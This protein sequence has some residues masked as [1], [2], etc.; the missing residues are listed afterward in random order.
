[1]D[2]QTGDT[3]CETARLVE[4]GL[5]HIA[6]GETIPTSVH[7]VSVSI[8]DLASVVAFESKDEQTLRRIRRGYPRFRVHPYVALVAALAKEE[9]GNRPEDI[10]LTCSVEAG[11][12]AAAHACLPPEALVEECGVA[13]VAFPYG[14][15]QGR[16]VRDFVQHTGCHLS[17]REAEDLL[18]EAGVVAA[19]QPEV[20]MAER[21]EERVVATLAA[22]YGIDD[23]AAV[24][25]R[26]SGMN[27]VYAAIA[28]IDD[29]Q[30]ERGRRRW[31]QLGWIFFDTVKLFEK[32]VVDMRH[33]TL[34]NAFDLDAVA[35]LVADRGD[36]AGIVTEAPSNP[37]MQTADLPALRRIA[38]GHACALVV[39]ATI[40]TP[41]NIDVLP[42]ADVVCESLT[43][44]A[45]GSA[46][47]LM[48]AVIVNRASAFAVP[49]MDRLQGFGDSPYQADVARVAYRIQGYRDRMAQVNANAI[50]LADFFH[51]HRA[52]GHVHYAYEPS[53]RENYLR[54][55][56]TPASPGGLLMLDLNVP[57]E[58]VYDVLAVAKGPSF[59]AEFTMA[60]PQ[61]FIAHFDLLSNPQGRDLLRAHGLHRDM[62]RVS[63]GIEDG[64]RIVQVFDEALSRALAGHGTRG[65]ATTRRDTRRQL[66]P[67]R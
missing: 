5:T 45:T 15:E 53:S 17:S 34:S 51:R 4:Q 24:S 57:L 28:S 21:S 6:A 40:G 39:D 7:G 2:A 66:P 11:R 25:L 41:Y 60:S 9:R 23:P 29:V 47:V 62:L 32:R 3:C 63:V 36:V 20:R 42:Y 31:L 38:D 55:E 59:G 50:L 44:Y 54:L 46:D 52:V 58:Q 22:A 43:K 26:N 33:E 18:V 10:V 12:R 35:R 61:V 56:R 37:L 30:R 16:R 64:E 49:V 14:S 1:M 27:A 48:G 65:G 19:R 67:V 8:P 13:G